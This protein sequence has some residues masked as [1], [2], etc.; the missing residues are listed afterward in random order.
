MRV[1]HCIRRGSAVRNELT[2]ETAHA[3]MREL[4]RSA[5]RRGSY[6]VYLIGGT[7]AVLSGWRAATVDAD[8]YCERDDIFR[9]IQRIKDTFQVNVELVRPEH[10]V[11][12]LAGSSER[13]VFVETIDR[14]SFYH[15]D[16]YAQVL[17]KVVRGLRR[18]MED[19]NHFLDSGMVDAD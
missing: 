12:G 6:R 7:T 16:P 5:P 17:S 10:F 3:L 1:V 19:A 2:R 9:D 15:Y 4:A 14:V 8:L 13:H 18:D 11:P